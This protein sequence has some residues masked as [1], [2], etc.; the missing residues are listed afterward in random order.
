MKLAITT[1]WEI[2]IA[3][4]NISAQQYQFQTV[5]FQTWDCLGYFSFLS[6]E[7]REMGSAYVGIVM[8]GRSGCLAQNCH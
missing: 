3:A 7:R 6:L 2:N 1:G 4:D 8:S 5:I